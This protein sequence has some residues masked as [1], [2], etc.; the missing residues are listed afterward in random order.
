VGEVYGTEWYSTE[1]QEIRTGIQGW[2]QI[3]N[4]RAKSANF[5]LLLLLL[6]NLLLLLLLFSF[7]GFKFN[8]HTP[9]NNVND[10]N[11]ERDSLNVLFG[12]F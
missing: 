3:I 10:H 8:A 11:K 12:D 5:L 2:S 7:G 9:Q 6:F 4:R 1:N